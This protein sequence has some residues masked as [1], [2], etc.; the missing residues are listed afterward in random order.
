MKHLYKSHLKEGLRRKYQDRREF[1]VVC[2]FGSLVLGYFMG[3]LALYLWP[4]VPMCL[5]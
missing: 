5:L 2:L 1:W 4:R 3:H